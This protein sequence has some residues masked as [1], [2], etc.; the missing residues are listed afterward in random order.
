MFYYEMPKKRNKLQELGPQ[1]S[2]FHFFQHVT[3]ILLEAFITYYLNVRKKSEDKPSYAQIAH[4]ICR[5]QPMAVVLLCKT[6]LRLRVFLKHKVVGQLPH[7]QR[8]M[9]AGIAG[10]EKYIGIYL[11]MAVGKSPVGIGDDNAAYARELECLVGMGRQ[12]VASDVGLLVEKEERLDDTCRHRLAVRR[13]IIFQQYYLT[14]ADSLIENFSMGCNTSAC[15]VIDKTRKAIKPLKLPLDR[16]LQRALVACSCEQAE[17]IA[18][19]LRGEVYRTG[20]IPEEWG[21][22][23]D[24]VFSSRSAHKLKAVVA[25]KREIVIE[26]AAGSAQN[27][28]QLV[29]RMTVTIYEHGEQVELLG[30]LRMAHSLKSKK[31]WP[32]PSRLYDLR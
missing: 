7:P 20:D 2:Q 21:M 12:L 10:K 6:L 19:L 27:L 9:M 32:S 23:T 14:L 17:K 28:T 29:G 31:S 8:D 26:I 1:S 25:E 13:G 16:M 3:N 5:E 18:H 30:I 24:I 22:G 11:L 15:G 4:H